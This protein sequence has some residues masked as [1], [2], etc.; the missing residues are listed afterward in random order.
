MNKPL[1]DAESRLKR[2]KF[3]SWHRGWKECDLILGSFADERLSGLTEP[4][5][6]AYEQ[7]LEE[8]D[9]VIWRWLTNKEAPPQHLAGIIAM[10]DGYGRQV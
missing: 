6:D 4:E 8:D 2:L 3:R 7:L 1:T 5:L 9:D 10:L